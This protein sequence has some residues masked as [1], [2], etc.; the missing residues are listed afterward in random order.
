MKKL[1]ITLVLCLCIISFAANGLSAEGEKIFPF[2]GQAKTDNVNVRA[3]GSQNFEILCK[4]NTD[5]LIYVL[6]ETYGWYKIKLPRQADCYVSGNFIDIN[7]MTGISKTSNLNLR[8]RPNK[9]SSIIGQIKKDEAV[10]IVNQNLDGW[11]QIQPPESSFGWI[12]ADLVEFYSSPDASRNAIQPEQLNVSQHFIIQ[13]KIERVGFTFGKKP[14]SHKL[15]I[16]NKFAYYLKSSKCN[17]KDFEGKIVSV[18]GKIFQEKNYKP[19]IDVERIEIP[20]Q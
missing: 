20:K 11:Y 9:E 5:D 13:G 18:S 2:I 7:G 14:S 15:I 1:S 19:I 16:N 3:G 8:A 6:E 17:L 10:T 4:I 12:S